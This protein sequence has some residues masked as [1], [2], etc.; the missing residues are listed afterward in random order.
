MRPFEYILSY[1]SKTHGGKVPLIVL[2]HGGPHSVFAA[3]WKL[4]VAFLNSLGYAVCQGASRVDCHVVFCILFCVGLL[5]SVRSGPPRS[6]LPGLDGI[7]EEAPG[8]TAGAHRD[9]GT[10]P[11]AVRYA[12][13]AAN[14]MSRFTL[15]HS[16]APTGCGRCSGGAGACTANENQPRPRTGWIH[17]G[18][19]RGVPGRAC[20]S[21]TP[22]GVQGRR[23]AQPRYSST[24]SRQQQSMAKACYAVLNKN[25]LPHARLVHLLMENLSI[26]RCLLRSDQSGGGGNDRRHPG[27]VCGVFR[28]PCCPIGLFHGHWLTSAS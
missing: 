5:V 22:R 14:Q 26:C 27:L 23:A 8:G 10:C 2:P 15:F 25:R 1:P 21:A 7:R 3:D 19:A 16:Y 11:L 13:R 20:D 9:N 17:G 24:A 28:P 12:W 6:E 4:S 18:L